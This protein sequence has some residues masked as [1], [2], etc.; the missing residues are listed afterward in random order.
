MEVRVEIRS[1]EGMVAQVVNLITHGYRYYFT[2]R[3]KEGKDPGEV[4][5]R[6]LADYEADLP[7]WT[8]ERRRRVGKA[9]FRY[10]R[11]ERTFILLATEGEASRFWREDKSRIRDV[12]NIP[13]R[14][15]G[16]S[17]SYRRGGNA[18]LAPGE[19]EE[20]NELWDRYRE[21]LARGEKR[22]A[23]PPPPRRDMKWHAHVRLDDETY[24]G[25][26]AYFLNIAC[27]RQAD[28]IAREFWELPF[29]PYRPLRVQL[30]NI[31][32]AVNR[33]RFLAGYDRVPV[34]VIRFKR[35]IVRPFGEDPSVRVRRLGIDCGPTPG[36]TIEF[37]ES[38]SGRSAA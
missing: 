31:L 14:F 4:D 27:H 30:L 21:A 32:R 1:I 8:R 6:M 24:A 33:T 38:A 9:N 2:G 26:K 18:R 28:F 25:I 22:P 7:K 13:V 12:R 3:V 11:F 29:E 23:K 36:D 34:S 19:R 20:R 37:V 15:K 10:L 35:T 5:R 17:I 16:Y